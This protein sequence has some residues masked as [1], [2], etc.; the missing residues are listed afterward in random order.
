MGAVRVGSVASSYGGYEIKPG[1]ESDRIVSKAK[2]FL[3]ENQN[4]LDQLFKDFGNY[5]AKELELRATIVYVDK[6]LAKVD[7]PTDELIET[8]HEIKPGF[9][10]GQIK[11]AINELAGEK[12]IRPVALAA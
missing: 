9:S 1:D 11:T 3:Q 7:C 10:L 12:Y 8:V 5:N 6:D 4:K 2:T